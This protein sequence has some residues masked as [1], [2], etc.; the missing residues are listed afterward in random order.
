MQ[1]QELENANK[2]ATGDNYNLIQDSSV[3]DSEIKKISV[4]QFTFHSLERVPCAKPFRRLLHTC[5]HTHTH[6]HNHAQSQ[7]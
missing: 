2:N 3:K 1:K 6:N 4:S 7:K 5:T